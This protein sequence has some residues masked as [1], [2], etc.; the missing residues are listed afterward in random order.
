[1]H[2]NCIVKFDEVFVGWASRPHKKY[3][4]D[5]KQLI[6]E[7][8]PENPVLNRQD[9]CSTINMVD[10]YYIFSGLGYLGQVAIAGN[11]M[12][13]P[14]NQNQSGSSAKQSLE[15]GLAALKGR[16]YDRAIAL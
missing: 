12:V 7:T 1:M 16:D 10:V 4:L 14:P 9:A 11:V 8:S 15:A 6:Y 2:L 3:N 13:S 5:A